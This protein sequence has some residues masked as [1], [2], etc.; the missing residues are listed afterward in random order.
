M[1]ASANPTASVGPNNMWQFGRQGT[2]YKKLKLFEIKWPWKMDCYILRYDVGS[3]IPWHTDPVSSGQ[4]WRFDLVLWGFHKGGH[5]MTELLEM[6][7]FGLRR[8]INVMDR[9]LVFRSDVNRHCV[10]TILKGR[11][12]VLS[13]GWI[14]G[15]WRE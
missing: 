6:S 15:D 4:H 12:Y 3:S 2:G 10:T 8:K 5:M 7:R 11:R 9:Y 14:K 1:N 13:V